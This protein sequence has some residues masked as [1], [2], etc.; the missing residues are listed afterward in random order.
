MTMQHDPGYGNPQQTPQ[1]VLH[2][3]RTEEPSGEHDEWEVVEVGL[4]GTLDQAMGPKTPVVIDLTLKNSKRN[5]E[6]GLDKD[7]KKVI[8]M[9]I[10]VIGDEVH[11]DTDFFFGVD[12][13]NDS[14]GD[15]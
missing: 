8:H 12:G 10:E 1:E 11:A 2:W 15:G 9:K 13:A 5:T 14:E 7:L 4:D 6:M 3:Y